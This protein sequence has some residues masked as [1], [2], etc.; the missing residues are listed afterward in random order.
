MTASG[1]VLAKGAGDGDERSIRAQSF[2]RPVTPN[3]AGG[4]GGQTP[5]TERQSL[6]G[7]SGAAARSR[8]GTLTGNN[9]APGSGANSPALRPVMGGGGYA[10]VPMDSRDISELGGNPFIDS[11]EAGYRDAPSSAAVAAGARSGGGPAE[12]LERLDPVESRSQT[13]GSMYR[14]HNS[15]A[16]GAGAGSSNAMREARRA[17]GMD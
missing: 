16:A 5:D 15:G 6:L 9:A 14:D 4:V 10:A 3:F 7:A 13:P 17:W 11:H 8:R 2:G 1:A 12:A